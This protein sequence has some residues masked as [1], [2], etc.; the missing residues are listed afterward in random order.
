MLRRGAEHSPSKES[1]ESKRYQAAESEK[2]EELI[3]LHGLG[4]RL[5]G[6]FLVTESMEYLPLS[7]SD[8]FECYSES[9]YDLELQEIAQS[10]NTAEEVIERLIQWTQQEEAKE[11]HRWLH[12][13]QMREYLY[14]TLKMFYTHQDR[15]LRKGSPA[16][17]YY[18]HH[19]S[20]QQQQRRQSFL[21]STNEG[22]EMTAWNAEEDE[23]LNSMFCLDLFDKMIDRWLSTRSAMSPMSLVNDG[24]H[25]KSYSTAT[26]SATESLRPLLSMDSDC[27]LPL[28]SM[29]ITASSDEIYRDLKT[30]IERSDLELNGTDI[31]EVDDERS[32]IRN[33]CHDIFKHFRRRIT[34]K[35]KKDHFMRMISTKH[36]LLVGGSQPHQQQ[37]PNMIQC[38]ICTKI[39]S[40]SKLDKN[41]YWHC[42]SCMFDVCHACSVRIQSETTPCCDAQHAMIH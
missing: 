23:S 2:V 4:S 15:L 33:Q 35:C 22:E 26:T 41:F 40:E 20:H 39:V 12:E 16:S 42:P 27:T 6:S 13:A 7:L 30:G 9:C 38:G 5:T 3:R 31:I 19:H 1:L 10:V 14:R 28:T 32:L 36:A 34:L 8:I 24:N 11:E 25:K 21:N 17:Y 37:A 29:S 18:Y